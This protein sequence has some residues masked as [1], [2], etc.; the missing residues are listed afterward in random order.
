[1]SMSQFLMEVNKVTLCCREPCL[2]GCACGESYDIDY[3]KSVGWHNTSPWTLLGVPAGTTKY[4][5]IKPVRIEV[6]MKCLDIVSLMLALEGVGAVNFETNRHTR[7]D[8]M[9][10]E[11]RVSDG[12]IVEYKFRNC[13]L[14]IIGL[15]DLESDGEE[16]PYD[17]WFFADG[18]VKL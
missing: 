6:N 12:A 2:S 14:D 15:S 4:Q 16:V 18:V 1:M 5:H 9:I 8:H 10:V 3:V 7:F 17:V 13:R 11:A